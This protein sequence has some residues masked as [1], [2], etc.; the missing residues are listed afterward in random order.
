M[1]LISAVHIVLSTYNGFYDENC[2]NISNS[3]SEKRSES[4]SVSGSKSIGF[5]GVLFG[6]DDVPEVISEVFPYGA[7]KW[8]LFLGISILV[9]KMVSESLLMIVEFVLFLLSA[10][11]STVP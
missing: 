6:F 9:L 4:L 3:W 1:K 11:E 10:D 2:I 7:G 8:L 5:L